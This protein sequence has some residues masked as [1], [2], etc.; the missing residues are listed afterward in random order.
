MIST[1]LKNMTEI[2]SKIYL[3]GKLHHNALKYKFYEKYDIIDVYHKIFEHTKFLDKYNPTLRERIYYIE[4]NYTEVQLCQY[5]NLNK[6][7]YKSNT[8]SLTTTCGDNQC[9]SERQSQYLKNK[10][11]SSYREHR[12][13]ILCNAEFICMK[14]SKKKYCN[15]KCACKAHKYVRTEEIRIKISNSNKLVHN[16][17]EWRQSKNQI[18]KKSYKKISETMKRK[19]ASG[20]F[21]PNITNSWTSFSAFIFD[22]SGNK[23]KFRSTWD[24]AF[25]LLNPEC[26]YEKFRI[27][28][29][30]NDTWHNYI[31]DFIDDVNRILYEI[32]PNSQRDDPKNI[33]KMLSATSWSESNGFS[34]RIISDEWFYENANRID[35]I[36]HPQL[37][38]GMS[39]F[40]NE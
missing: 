19:I 14:V 16:D 3:N 18:Y 34:Y 37:L 29:N 13:C 15:I 40:L 24:A 27:P 36:A 8:L 30:Y 20:D 4:Q 17:P 38:K 11:Y 2:L 6:L 12:F 25:Q 31:I 28:Y 5:C 33:C 9:K 21:T 1:K 10:D 26:K 23:M 35:Y 7:K 39:Q 22:D 32:K